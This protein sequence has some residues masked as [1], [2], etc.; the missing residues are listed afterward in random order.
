MDISLVAAESKEAFFK[1]LSICIDEKVSNS[2]AE[3]VKTFAEQF[4]ENPA[5]D[6]L[7]GKSL[8]D[9]YGSAFAWWNFIQQRQPDQ[10]KVR[11]F[12]PTLEE[13]GWLCGHTVIAV[14]QQDMPFLVDS[15]R[16]EVTRRNLD[17]H[18]IH[19]SIMTI[20]RDDKGQLKELAVK[21]A[22]VRNT[23]AKTYGQEALV[24]LEIDLHTDESA[25]AD[26]NS[27]LVSL[28][29]DVSI[30]VTDYK[31]L[32]A[33]AE[34]TAENLSLAKGKAVADIS[35]EAQ[36]FMQWMTDG[37]FTFLGY[38]EYEFTGTN[39]SR[40]LKENPEKRLG[41]FRKHPRDDE[42]VKVTDFNSG[43]ERFHLSTQVLSFTKSAVRSRVHR[44]AYSDYVVVK[45]FDK[46]GN[47]IG[48]S[49]F[50]GLYTS[51][52][53][54]LSPSKIPVIRQKVNNVLDRSGLDL[55]SH[56][57]KSLRQVLETFP[58]DELFQR[59]ESELFET[60]LAVAQ[61]KERHMVRLF[62]R[63]DPYG[64]FVNAIVY[65]P[66]DTFSTE[67]RERIQELIG[68]A[69]HAE[70]DEF[71]TYFSE[72]LLARTHIVFRVDSGTGLDFDVKRLEKQIVDITRS[73]EDRLRDSLREFQG[74]EQEIGR[75]HV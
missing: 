59:S 11:V 40:S 73:W 28:L 45:R 66:R 64:K 5:L 4:Y 30:S 43:M 20:A 25:M 44:G 41:L 55:M 34:A 12:N 57:G 65:V 49:R 50:L 7:E 23:K 19:S 58:R 36:S 38:T 62:M 22:K 46:K 21:G 35:S 42:Q 33:Q 31:T 6:E 18:A 75:A 52:V 37:H 56:D 63:P 69:V 70:E 72:S 61:I 17:I 3:E 48:E 53:Y 68:E 24:Y 1:Q 54:T 15:I 47:V 10:P 14:L 9:V 67:I 26:L 29:D 39:G 32:L 2:Q 71:T 74:E 8:N 60:T 13:D 51:P 16:I 27:S